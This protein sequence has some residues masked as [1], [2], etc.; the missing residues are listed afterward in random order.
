MVEDT[1]D[2]Y[3]LTLIGKDGEYSK[4]YY[5][6]KEAALKTAEAMDCNGFVEKCSPYDND[7]P[8]WM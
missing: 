7:V 6:S 1:M 8:E 3:R 5:H 4:E 2:V